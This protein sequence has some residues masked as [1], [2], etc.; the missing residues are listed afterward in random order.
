MI[1]VFGGTFD[2]PHLGHLILAEEARYQLNL[3]KVLWVLTPVSPLK[4]DLD[5]TPHQIRLELVAAAIKDNSH[6][7]LSRVDIDRPPPYYAYETLQILAETYSRDNLIYLMGGDSL[8]DLS[9]WKAPQE[10]FNN[11]HSIAVM[12]RPGDGIDLMELQLIIPNIAERVQWVAAPFVDI[13]SSAIRRRLKQGEPV[14][15]FLLNDVYEIIRKNK[16]YHKENK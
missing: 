9:R 14:K 6:F 11:C 8:S 2:P 4:P 10:L 5:I 16:Y 15:Y 3:E 1:G 7:D 13:S 12:R